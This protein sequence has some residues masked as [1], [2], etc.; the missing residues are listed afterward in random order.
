MPSLAR[1]VNIADLRLMAK[2]RL[3]RSVF[4]AVV[5]A[6]FE[7]PEPHVAELARIGVPRAKI[8]T[9]RGLGSEGTARR[10]A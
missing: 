6:T 9:L 8:I 5:V 1:A 4:D 7:H 2:R 3:P 10:G